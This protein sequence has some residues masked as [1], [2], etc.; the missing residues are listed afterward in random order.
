M[1][2]VIVSIL[3][4]VILISGLLIG[5]D[6]VLTGSGNLKTENFPFSDFTQVEVSSAF[7]VKI[8]QSDSYSVAVTVDDNLVEYIDVSQEGITLKIGFKTI[9]MRGPATLKAT[10]TMPLIH[11][12][13]ILEASE[14]NISGFSTT[15]DIDIKIRQAGKVTGDLK[16][17]NV[18][19]NLEE[20]SSIQLDGS[21]NDLIAE[22]NDASK[23]NL[24]NFAVKNAHLSLSDASTGTVKLDGRL[25]ADLRGASNLFYV[26]EPTMGTINTLDASK[27]NKK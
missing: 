27:I 25:D 15:D 21:A 13:Y 19:L 4:L 16:S 17:G 1:K 12:L 2:N 14:C 8:T 22:V 24:G 20:A 7:E 3:T 6:N 11:G 18:K 23:M 10:I 5:C 26:G 9:T